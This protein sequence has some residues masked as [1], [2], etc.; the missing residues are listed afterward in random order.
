M[1]T[2]KPQNNIEDNVSSFTG[3]NK[4]NQVNAWYTNKSTALAWCCYEMMITYQCASKT[5][6]NASADL[7][8]DMLKEHSK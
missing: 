8:T 5:I 7:H 4:S 1:E 2:D 3:G 6:T